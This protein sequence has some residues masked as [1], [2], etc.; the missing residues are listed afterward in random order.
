MT[1]LDKPAE[2]QSAKPFVFVLMPFKEKFQD[3]YHLGIKAAAA[4][5][6]AYA[7]RVDEQ[8]FSEGIL[9]RIYGQISSADVIVADMTDRNPN[10]FYEVGYAH[11]IG[12]SVI[13][14]VRDESEIP[15]DLRHQQHIVYGSSIV[16]LKKKLTDKLAWAVRV[17]HRHTRLQ[18]AVT[19]QRTEIPEVELPYEELPV[20]REFV[21]PFTN[22][23]EAGN[24]IE[25]DLAVRNASMKRA[26]SVEHIY[27]LSSQ[28]SALAPLAILESG[29]TEPITPIM[30]DNTDFMFQYRL[31][32]KLVALEPDAADIIRLRFRPR[33]IPP[34]QCDF[35]LRL[36]GAEVYDFPFRLLVEISEER[37]RANP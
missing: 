2:L 15:F 25:V 24:T 9:E 27:L 37:A 12:R 16:E 7:E 30:R 19:Y 10:V 35:V 23:W 33:D 17:A 8:M 21:Y 29:R 1:L 13:L 3:I 5:A 36:H 22:A 31:R 11:G 14:M 18:F 28:K 34:V 4:E 20:I 26:G 6:G 32:E